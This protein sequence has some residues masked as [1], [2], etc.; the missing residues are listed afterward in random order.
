[1][2]AQ[3]SPSDNSETETVPDEQPEP[4]RLP[5]E[6]MPDETPLAWSAFTRYR[7][8][9]KR[10]LLDAYRLETGRIQARILTGQW[11]GWYRRFEWKARATAYDEYRDRIQREAREKTHR[12]EIEGFRSRQR[13]LA[14][15]AT[16]T[17]VVLLQKVNERLKTLKV[18]DIKP[19]MLPAFIRAAASVSQIASGAEADALGIDDLLNQLDEHEQGSDATEPD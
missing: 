12:E 18:S 13:R 11:S 1:M 17:S 5:W 2:S 10:S 6:R 4:E 14:S 15:T 9:P 19:G 7:D 3:P 8:M 16:E